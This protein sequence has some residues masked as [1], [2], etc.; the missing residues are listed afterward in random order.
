MVTI[1]KLLELHFLT[2][3]NE[4]NK[5]GHNDDLADLY[6]YIMAEFSRKNNC[7]TSEGGVCFQVDGVL[8]VK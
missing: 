3:N 6:I 5:N 1:W 8:P 7:G 4:I 2:L